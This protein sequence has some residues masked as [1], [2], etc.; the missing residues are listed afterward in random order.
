M[1]NVP[2][3]V[4]ALSGPDKGRDGALRLQLLEVSNIDI[5]V[6]LESVLK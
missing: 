2:V 5:N 6:H 4:P 3:L 1:R